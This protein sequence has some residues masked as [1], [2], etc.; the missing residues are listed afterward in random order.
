MFYLIYFASTLQPL[1][2]RYIIMGPHFHLPWLFYV[3]SQRLQLLSP[4]SLP[5]VFSFISH[6]NEDLKAPGQPE[7]HVRGGG[8]GRGWAGHK[9]QGSGGGSGKNIH[10]LEQNDRER[11]SSKCRLRGRVWS[12]RE[13]HCSARARKYRSPLWTAAEL[14]ASYFVHIFPTRAQRTG[15]QPWTWR[16]DCWRLTAKATASA[17]SRALT[18]P[19]RC[20]WAQQLGPLGCTGAAQHMLPPDWRPCRI[21]TC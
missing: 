16:A 19:T 10:E 2:L 6:P 12:L 15:G 5:V 1:N 9:S 20:R 13:E 21:I 8:I 17:A 3:R 11:G 18:P 14:T 7:R 4:I